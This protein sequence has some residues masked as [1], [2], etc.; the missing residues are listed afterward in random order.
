MTQPGRNDICPCGSQKKYKK[1]CGF[2]AQAQKQLRS[3]AFTYGPLA[4]MAGLSGKGLADRMFKV[5][6]KPEDGVERKPIIAKKQT[7]AD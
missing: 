2:K 3:R 6:S 4:A 1:C 5:V 7:A